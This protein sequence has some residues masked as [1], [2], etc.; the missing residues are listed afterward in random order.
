M[1]PSDPKDSSDTPTREVKPEPA[2]PEKVTGGV[3][4]NEVIGAF[5]LITLILEGKSSLTVLAEPFKGCR[6]LGDGIAHLAAL[7][8]ITFGGWVLYAGIFLAAVIG[9]ACGAKSVIDRIRSQRRAE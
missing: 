4:T 2:K 9:L 5:G 1:N 6:S 3:K 8:D 7:P